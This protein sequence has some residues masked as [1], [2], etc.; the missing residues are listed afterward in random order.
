MDQPL[1][2]ARCMHYYSRADQQPD[3]TNL[4]R[5]WFSLGYMAAGSAVFFCNDRETRWQ[6]GEM[7]FVPLECRYHARYDGVPHSEF[8]TLHFHFRPY[9]EPIGNRTFP[10]QALPA[11]RDALRHLQAILAGQTDPARALQTLGHIYTLLGD[12]FPLLSREETPPV[13]PQIWPAVS[14][15]S[16]HYAQHITIEELAAL[17]H[18]SVSNFHNRFRQEMKL[19]P[20]AFKNKLCISQAARILG[21]ER[22]AS[23]E[24]IS[25]KLGFES[26]AYFRRVF[27]QYTG[28][29]PREFR[30]RALNEL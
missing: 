14:Y 28:Y 3:Y 7:I 12:V 1:T 26:S 22:D 9:A 16:S 13:H 10:L 20:I 25:S 19:P 2:M 17:C 8:Y 11:P 6:T 24:E 18:M 15:I 5:P 29:S 23:I 21:S 27:R 30:N 4:P